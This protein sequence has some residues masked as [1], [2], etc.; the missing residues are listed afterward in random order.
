MAAASTDPIPSCDKPRIALAV[1]AL[2]AIGSIA[3]SE[4]IG[5]ITIVIALDTTAHANQSHTDGT[6]SAT[7][8]TAR[9]PTVT[10]TWIPAL[11]GEGWL[12]ASDSACWD[13]S[14][15]DAAAEE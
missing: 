3:R 9:T 15:C 14:P 11:R 8:T 10:S 5:P 6:P 12:A 4:D 13:G 1:P 2:A 7:T